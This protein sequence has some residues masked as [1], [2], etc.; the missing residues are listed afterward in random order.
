[1]PVKD[2]AAVPLPGENG[3]LGMLLVANRLASISTFKQDELALFETLAN[4]ASVALDNGR[5]FARLNREVADRTHQALHDALTGLPNRELLDLR[6]AEAVATSERSG[7]GVA[8]LLLD[9]EG[10]KEVNDTLGH[11]TGDLL[12]RQVARSLRE[13]LPPEATLA[14]FGGD[15]FVAVAPVVGRSDATR[16][17][18]AMLAALS[19]PF[20]QGELSIALGANV[21]VALFPEHGIEPATLLQRA[22]VAMYA[23]KAAH[24]GYDI[25]SVD[26]DPFTS[27]RL[28]LVGSLR[29]AIGREEIEVF[30]QPQIDLASGL[31][32]GAEGLVRWRHPELGLLPPQEFIAAVEQTNIIQPLTR[33]VLQLALASARIWRGNGYE[34]GVAVNLSV[35][36]LLDP[37]LPGE[38][39]DALIAEGF[40]AEH[41]TLEITENSVMTESRRL[42][43]VLSQLREMGVRL[44]IDDFGT[45]YSSL[46]HLRRIP[47][48]EI[49][50]DKSFVIGLT[51]DDQDAA[52]V[53]STIELG[54]QLGLRVVA[55][56][57][58]SQDTLERFREY[59]C[60]AVQGFAISR[61]R[62]P[63]NFATW[64]A[65]HG[66]ARLP[67]TTLAPDQ[68]TDGSSG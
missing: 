43:G 5:L 36:S 22:D 46:A 39:L 48:S 64:L 19:A 60:D 42:M 65:E 13:G 31:T 3:P 58:E 61:P 9:L 68:L 41:L 66:V 62:P 18:D 16:I 26:R 14:R 32:V 35:R 27:R 4:H 37:G 45:G 7:D 59:G 47:V 53:R 40:P 23:A 12:L 11:H 56:G 67:Q 57:V 30:F 15:E 2:A 49:K 55:E 20:S 33:R 44:S 6:L 34:M 29:E 54:H 51:L 28:A 8:V 50:I 21:G 38:V 52:I 1:M 63:D 25:Y 24:A 10:F 17:A